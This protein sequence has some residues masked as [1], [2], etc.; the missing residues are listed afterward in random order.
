[1]KKSID[2]NIIRETIK[3][4]F[5]FQCLD[6]G[7][8]PHCE[9]EN[10]FMRDVLFVKCLSGLDCSYKLAYG[11]RINCLCPTRKELYGMYK[12]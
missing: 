10:V 7:G 2:P 6:E 12:I 5:N 1:M 3:C 8:K 4:R 9:I 11:N